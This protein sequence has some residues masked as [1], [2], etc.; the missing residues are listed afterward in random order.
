MTATPRSSSRWASVDRRMQPSPIT[1][2]SLALLGMTKGRP[3]LGRPSSE[4]AALHFLEEVIAVDVL[5]IVFR[6]GRE[7]VVVILARAVLRHLL[8][9]L[10][11][12]SNQLG[13]LFLVHGDRGKRYTEVYTAR[14]AAPAVAGSVTCQ[15]RLGGLAGGRA[16]SDSGA[17]SPIR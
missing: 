6:L 12:L 11:V 8:G 14:T 2:R 16:A 15:R 7:R 17:S 9:A 13:E 5:R 4:L 3:R 10:G 1:C